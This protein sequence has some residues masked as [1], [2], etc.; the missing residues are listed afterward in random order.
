MSDTTPAGDILF[1]ELSGIDHVRFWMWFRT[2]EWVSDDAITPWLERV[3]L[4]DDAVVLARNYSGGMK[5]RLT[6]IISCVGDPRVLF[7]DEPTTGECE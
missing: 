5:R 6:F 4:T 2:G 7:L 1:D 3:R